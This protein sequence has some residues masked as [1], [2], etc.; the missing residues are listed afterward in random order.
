MGRFL[1]V[2]QE[3]K[4]RLVIALSVIFLTGFLCGLLVSGKV[5]LAWLKSAPNDPYLTFVFEA[6]DLIEENYWQKLSEAQLTELYR[7]AAEKLT[8]LP[9]ILKEKNKAELENL[10]LRLWP[11]FDNQKKK[12]FAVNLT[13]LVLTSLSP[14]GR[15]RLYTQQEE[16]ELKNKVSNV[17]PQEDLYQVLEADRQASKEEISQKA[18]AKIEQL[19][20]EAQT[21]PQAAEQLEKT[22]YASEVLTD[23]HTRQLYDQTGAEPTVFAK[24]INEDIVQLKIKQL[25]PFTFEEF[26]NQL[27]KVSGTTLILD[28]RGNFGGAIDLLPYFLG[29]FIG[30]NQYAYEFLHQGVYQPFKTQTGW[31]AQLLPYKKVVVLIDEGTQSSAEVMAAVLKKYNVGVLL[32]RRTKGWGTVEKVFPLKTKIDEQKSYSVFLVHSL[33]LDENNQPIEGRGVEPTIDLAN[34][35]W[36]KELLAYFN[37]PALITVVKE[38]T[39]Q[40]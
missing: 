1:K 27:K 6:Y 31:L 9:Q 12:E 23:N 8:G 21:N 29:P 19:K 32:G 36:E 26:Q 4:I 38:L 15:S 33:T 5:K 35:E 14:A 24:K 16:T 7:L 37:Y 28:L 40:P 39:A 17:N 34:S 18:Q 20:K 11:K 3:R 25:S 10:L 2:L 22:A 13:D 30:Q